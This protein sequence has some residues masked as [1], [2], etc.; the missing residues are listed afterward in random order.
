MMILLLSQLR[1][2]GWM[3]KSCRWS[4]LKCQPFS[5]IMISLY[6]VSYFWPATG[7]FHF[8]DF[9]LL[10]RGRAAA[11]TKGTCSKKVRFKKVELLTSFSHPLGIAL[12]KPK[13]KTCK[14]E[15][16]ALPMWHTHTCICVARSRTHITK[17]SL[18][19]SQTVC[20]RH[21]LNKVLSCDTVYSTYK[22]KVSTC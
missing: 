17:K 1:I 18:S 21:R 15:G 12:R 16:V 3:L 8:G 4:S 11:S 22:S 9:E 7:P 14:F 6:K 10:T 19:W 2:Q 13:G 20:S 5:V